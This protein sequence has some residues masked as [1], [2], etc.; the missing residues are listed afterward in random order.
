[1]TLADTM[2]CLGSFSAGESFLVLA[3]EH[4]KIFARDGWTKPRLK[5]ALYAAARRT[6]A[7]LKRGGK[8]AGEVEPADETTW[9]HRGNGPEDI[10]IVVAG[11]G[12]G[13]HS[14]FIPS[15]SR[16]RNSLAVTRPIRITKEASG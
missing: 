11:G 12:P 15:W 4:V 5:H 14:A 9:V 13:G 1:M 8:V 3:P 10:H 6:R 2:A 7:D 16:A